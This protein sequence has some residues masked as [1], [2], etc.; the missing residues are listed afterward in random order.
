MEPW[1]APTRMSGLHAARILSAR[2]RI[3]AGSEA[4]QVYLSRIPV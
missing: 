3:L 2:A 1:A 4:R